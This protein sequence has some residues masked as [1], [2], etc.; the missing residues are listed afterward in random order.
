MAAAKLCMPANRARGAKGSC[1]AL[2]ELGFSGTQSFSAEYA[3]PAKA[4]HASMQLL[5]RFTGLQQ[6]ANAAIKHSE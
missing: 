1:N 6:R 2:L 5:A 4:A 3:D